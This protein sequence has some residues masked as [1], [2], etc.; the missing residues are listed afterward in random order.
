MPPGFPPSKCLVPLHTLGH[1]PPESFQAPLEPD[2]VSQSNNPSS[3]ASSS[4][5]LSAP[6]NEP[7]SSRH[8]QSQWTHR[9]DVTRETPDGE[10]PASLQ[11]NSESSFALSAAEAVV[12]NQPIIDNTSHDITQPPH[13]HN[14]PGS[15]STHE[16]DLTI[17]SLTQGQARSTSFYTGTD[18]SGH[19]NYPFIT[20]S[21]SHFLDF[22]VNGDNGYTAYRADFPYL[23]NTNNSTHAHLCTTVACTDPGCYTHTNL[24]LLQEHY[25]I[26]IGSIFAHIDHEG[27][28]YNDDISIDGDHERQSNRAQPNLWDND[29]MDQAK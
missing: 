4:M 12:F 1:S 10:V 24:S 3:F 15:A 19:G 22:H 27:Q 5:R 18:T 23:L 26:G 9:S 13:P 21:T 16:D 14:R 29:G 8:G 6:F 28:T 25:L 7:G 17:D 20:N 11:E 2:S